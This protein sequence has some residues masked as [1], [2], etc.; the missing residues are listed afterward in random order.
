MR[1]Q[2]LLRKRELPPCP[3][4]YSP[5]GFAVKAGLVTTRVTCINLAVGPS[6]DSQTSSLPVSHSFSTL[7]AWLP[8]SSCALANAIAAVP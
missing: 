2:S 3:A 1:S 5:D 7:G 4:P 6:Q 8:K